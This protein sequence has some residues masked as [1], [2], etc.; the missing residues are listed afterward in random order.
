LDDGERVLEAGRLA[1][2]RRCRERARHAAGCTPSRATEYEW[3]G[4][5]QVALRRGAID[6][7]DAT[8]ITGRHR[9]PSGEIVNI[10]RD[11]G[12]LEVL[13][14]MSG[15]QTLYPVAGGTLAR[16]DRA[17]EYRLTSQGLT[18]IEN[19]SSPKAAELAA[20]RITAEEAPSAV[21]LLAEGKIEDA[22]RV[23]R[24]QF[25]TDP[26]PFA[27]ATLTRR[28]Y[29]YLANRRTAEALALLELSTELH[30]A[31]ATA[32][33]DLAEARFITGDTKGM[34]A[35]YET[36]FQHLDADTTLAAERKDALRENARKRMEAVRK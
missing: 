8:R 33:D 1:T 27:Q 28:G 25:E 14:L 3:P 36:M 31:S 5:A 34:I 2:P 17:T 10:R 22:R 20:T 21:E 29:Q 16:A 6:D 32:C 15:W 23:F 7:A 4:Y 13:D 30:P 26:K 11:G 12:T 18:V 24:E 9:L 35:A 19:A